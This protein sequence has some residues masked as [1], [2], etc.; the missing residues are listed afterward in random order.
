[1]CGECCKYFGNPGPQTKT[2]SSRGPAQTERLHTDRWFFISARRCTP[3]PTVCVG[4][5]L[6]VWQLVLA[7]ASLHCCVQYTR[8]SPPAADRIARSPTTTKTAGDKQNN[9]QCTTLRASRVQQA[10]TVCDNK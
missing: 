2:A 6:C 4:V 7:R 1:M 9:D 3:W 5:R 10:T 8:D